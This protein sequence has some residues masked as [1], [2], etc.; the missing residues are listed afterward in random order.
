M[1]QIET[2]NLAKSTILIFTDCFVFGGCE[3]VLVNLINSKEISEV[4][5]LLYSYNNNKDYR[6]AVKK[7]IRTAGLYPQNLL[8]NDSLFYKLNLKFKNRIIL[9]IIKLP[10]WFI[11][12]IGVFSIFNFLRLFIFFKK[13]RPDIIF[14]NNGGYP[15]AHTCRVAVFSAKLAGIKKIIFNVNN[16]A[17]KQKGFIDRII[18][19]YIARNVDKFVTASVAAKSCL[20]TRRFFDINKCVSIPNTVPDDFNN[21]ASTDVLRTEYN[22]DK[23]NKI[24]GSVGFLT[25][26]KGYH[27]LIDAIEIITK[28]L[29]DNLYFSVFIFGDGEERR[30]LEDQILSKNLQKVIHLPGY[31]QNI[32]DYIKCFDIFVLPSIENED[33]PYVIMEAMAIGKPVISTN[34]AGIPEQIDHGK[35]GFVCEPGNPISISN[36]IMD[37]LE[38]D[39]L[40]LLMGDWSKKKYEDT[41]EYSIVMR[42]YLHLFNTT[43]Q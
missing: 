37:L 22:I 20:S 35:N 21:L 18:D 5:R 30:N 10:F 9:K 42:K 24:I 39:E 38:N 36:A 12:K 43:M 1:A 15:G 13:I 14:I 3:N 17:A 33:L 41:F 11:Q 2:E 4:Y 8:S 32:K 29:G 25:K 19:K 40:S 26:R 7:K 31:K 34:V 16:I 27:I 6:K 28:R 23:N